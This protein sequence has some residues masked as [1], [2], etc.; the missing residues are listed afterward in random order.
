MKL[1]GTFYLR[2]ICLCALLVVSLSSYEQLNSGNLTQYTEKDGLPGAQVNSILVDKHGYLWVG[3][4]NGLARYDGYE[5]KRFYYNPNDT[6]S[7]HGLNV[8]PMFEDRHGKIWIGTHQ[9]YLNAYDPVLKNFRQYE[10][11]H[12]IKHTANIEVDVFAICGDNN[13][14]IYFGANTFYGQPISSTILYKDEDDD[15]L[16][17]LGIPD[18]LNVQN[19]LSMVRDQSGNIWCTSFSGLFKIDTNRKIHRVS[20]PALSR[21]FIINNEFAND[22]KFDKDGHMWLITSG[23]RLIDFDVEKNTY[24]V[25]TI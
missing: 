17:K 20:T 8:F 19:I 9:S 18:S 12:L 6:A 4:I 16:R 13:G 22:F 21:D 1:Q 23:D 3:T 7:V 15:N 2:I 10:F 25:L 14:R 11:A 5:F 24:N